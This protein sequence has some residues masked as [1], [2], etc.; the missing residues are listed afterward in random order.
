MHEWAKAVLLRLL[1]VPAEPKPPEGTASSVRVFRAGRNYYYWRLVQWAAM[2]LGIG[3]MV[4]GTFVGP[5]VLKKPAKNPPPAWLMAVWGVA[6]TGVVGLFVLSLPVTY[7]KQRIDYEMRWYIVTDRCLRVRSG[8]WSTGEFTMTF[9]NV[10]DIRISAGPLQRLLGLAD[11]KVTSAGGGGG[12]SEQLGSS[13][14]AV[15]AG[16]DCAEA[17]RE[18]IVGRLREYRDA[19]LGDP[20]DKQRHAAVSSAAVGRGEQPA[21]IDAARM[22]LAEARA[23]RVVLERGAGA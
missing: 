20:D 3:L 19:G 11:V 7:F 18:L 17:I 14:M 5:M 23:L 10:Q 15:F 12:G 1:K 13:H 8:I 21:A 4:V 16:V 9:A 2:Q 22:V 6:G